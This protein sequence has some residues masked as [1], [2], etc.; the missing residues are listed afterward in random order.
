MG[1]PVTVWPQYTFVTHRQTDTHTHRST[2]A[3]SPIYY[4]NGHKKFE[5]IALLLITVTK[6]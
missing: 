4:V 6:H 2:I 1:L 5:G 3:V